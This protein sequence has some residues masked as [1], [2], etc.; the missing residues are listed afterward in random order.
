[1]SNY[2]ESYENMSLDGSTS[3]SAGNRLQTAACNAKKRY[4]GPGFD[5]PPD[6]N[7]FVTNS[8]QK[9]KMTKVLI[10]VTSGP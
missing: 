7:W 6:E 10:S 4:W 9:I 5:P 1:M 3:S 8:E 2:E